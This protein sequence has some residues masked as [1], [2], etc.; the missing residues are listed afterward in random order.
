MMRFSGLT[1]VVLWLCG[2]GVAADSATKTAA[3]LTVY[4]EGVNAQG[5]N[6]AVMIFHGP[7]GWP[8]DNDA[9]YRAV[10]VPAHKG[11]MVVHVALPPGEYAIAVGHDVNV[12]KK[13]DKNWL[14]KPTE[15]WGMSNNPHAHLRAPEFAKAKVELSGNEE[16]HIR[17]Q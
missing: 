14:G 3:T 16:I 15:Q 1:M 2:I 10:V 13:V 6:I 8:E 17:M 7:K 12:N 9:A 11:T 4:V 5:G